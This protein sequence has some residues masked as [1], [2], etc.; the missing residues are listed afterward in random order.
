V[1]TECAGVAKRLGGDKA[2]CT[3]CTVGVVVEGAQQKEHFAHC[4]LLSNECCNTVNLLYATYSS[5]AHML[6]WGCD[7]MVIN[8][9]VR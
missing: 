2:V 1:E 8:K 3:M 4:V 5:M 9:L 7:H 6:L